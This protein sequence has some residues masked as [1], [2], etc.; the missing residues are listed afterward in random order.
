MRT[1]H[2]V[3]Y[4][5]C[6]SVSGWRV[7][8]DKLQ[9]VLRQANSNTSN[10]QVSQLKGILLKGKAGGGGEDTETC[11]GWRWCLAKGGTGAGDG[12][13][14]T[15]CK[16]AIPGFLQDPHNWACSFIWFYLLVGKTCFEKANFLWC[17]SQVYFSN[18]KTIKDTLNLHLVGRMCCTKHFRYFWHFCFCW[19]LFEV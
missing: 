17:T 7:E 11:A 16:V 5:S 13:V 2:S 19:I 15:Y 8:A 4:S 3:S 6:Y 12:A 9:R 18:T 10:R 14:R 1:L